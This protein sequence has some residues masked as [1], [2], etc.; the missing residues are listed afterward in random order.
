[1]NRIQKI[2]L[3]MIVFITIAVICAATAVIILYGKYGMPKAAAGL[4]FLGIAGLAGIGPAVFRK[5]AG[6]NVPD[7][8]DRL[9]SKNAATAG[10]ATAY[11]V[12]GFACM[13]P[14]SL[15]GPKASIEVTWLPLIFAGAGL[16]HFFAYS[17][18]ILIQYGR[19][20]PPRL[21]SRDEAAGG[22]QNE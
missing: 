7:E 8:R 16:S 2:S 10:F 20:L 1:M 14:F 18:A 5:D 15:L 12:T 22:N 3:W 9:I 19:G 4:A 6:A 11:A 13:L 21:S 17:A